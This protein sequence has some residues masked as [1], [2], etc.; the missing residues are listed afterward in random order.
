MPAPHVQF[1]LVFVIL[2][3][4]LPLRDFLLLCRVTGDSPEFETQPYE[5]IWYGIAWRGYEAISLKAK[6]FSTW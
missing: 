2:A 1:F 4:R 5:A 3:L 6:M